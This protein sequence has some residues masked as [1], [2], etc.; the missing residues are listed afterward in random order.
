[1]KRKTSPILSWLLTIGFAFIAFIAVFPLL[2][3]ILASFRPS[4]ELM[5][6]GITLIFDP[7][8]LTLD[9]FIYIFT[10]AGLYWTWFGNSVWISIVI[11]VLSLLFSSMV[12]YALAVYDFKGRNFFFLLVLIILMI[13]FE[14]L[15]L[16]LFQLMIKLQLVN[17]YTAVILP[18]IVAPIAVFFFRQYAL[19]LP[20]ELMDAARIDGCTEYGIFFKIMLP[21]M[22]PSLAAMAILQGLNSWN[23]FLWPLVVLR[24]NDMFTLPIGLAT[25]LTP[26]GNNYDILLAGS[27]MTIVPIVILFIFFQRYFIAGLTV[28]GVKG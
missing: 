4:T 18:A 17:T 15:M 16:P 24:S 22:G 3:L 23:N 19:G 1:M 14:I 10:E 13:P 11:V 27:V 20:K 7:S 26:Y 8:T 12:G 6:N 2:N 9:N 5:R 25:L 21:L 28:G